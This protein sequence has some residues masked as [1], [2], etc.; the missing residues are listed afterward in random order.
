[1]EKEQYKILGY[2]LDV[3]C[4]ILP[5]R[6][7]KGDKMNSEIYL[8]VSFPPLYM[9]TVHLRRKEKL[10]I[11]NHAKIRRDNLIL[12]FGFSGGGEDLEKGYTFSRKV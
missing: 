2:V 1:L 8:F 4:V 9:H 7:E 3:L 6:I 5:R 11:G 10:A 12:T